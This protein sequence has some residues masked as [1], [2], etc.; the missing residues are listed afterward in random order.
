M[1]YFFQFG[2]SPDLASRELANLLTQRHLKFHKQVLSPSEVI[3]TT[4]K[5]LDTE[6]LMSLLGGTLRIAPFVAACDQDH[7]EET[8]LRV[9]AKQEFT[10][11]LVFSLSFLNFHSEP[12][13]TAVHLKSELDKLG[14]TSRFNLP[15]Y[16]FQTPAIITAQHLHELIILRHQEKYQVYHTNQ[17]TASKDWSYRDRGRPVIDS[18]SGTLPLK[19]S[20]ML[21]NLATGTPIS[22]DTVIL[23]PFCGSG[24]ILSEAVVLGAQAVGIDI[25]PQAVAATEANLSWLKQSYPQ[26]NY[27]LFTQ[28]TTQI[29]PQ[30]FPLTPVD[31]VVTEGYLGSP[32][33][34]SLQDTIDQITSLEHL[35]QQSLLQLRTVLKPGGRVVIALAQ[36]RL[37]ESVKSLQNL[38]DT[39]ENSGYTRLTGPLVYSQPRARVKRAI[40]VLQNR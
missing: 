23:D 8:L 27:R 22:A 12:Q 34:L 26:A 5:P 31:A 40:Y 16:R 38:I 13:P 29:T 17:V 10:S 3:L 6:E 2:F 32:D 24:S 21:L 11:K 39:C 30:N 4:H 35:Y 18:K 7:L 20:R 14:I 33:Q 28:D 9:L 25:D 36:Y 37:L 15:K 1:Q 19:V